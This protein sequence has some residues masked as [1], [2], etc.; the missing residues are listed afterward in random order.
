MVIQ[1]RNLGAV[2]FDNYALISSDEILVDGG[3]AYEKL[4]SF[5]GIRVASVCLFNNENRWY[6]FADLALPEDYCGT[7]DGEFVTRI[8]DP[9]TIQR[10]NA[11]LYEV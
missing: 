9:G 6:L 2:A 7:S 5:T 1:L 8:D 4:Q 11:L 10:L 3:D